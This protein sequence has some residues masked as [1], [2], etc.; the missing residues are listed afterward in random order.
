MTILITGG[1]GYIGSH[2]CVTFLEA[3]HDVVVVDNLTNANPE[4]LNRV[5][6]ITGRK[7][8]F[9][10]ADIRDQPAMERLLKA[11]ACDAVVHFAGLKAVGESTEKPLEY[12]DNNV[13]GTIKLLSAMVASGVR[14]LIFS[15]SA[16]VY[17]EPEQLPIPEDHPLK[18]SNPYGRSKLMIEDILRDLALSDPSWRIGILRYFNPVGAHPSGLIGEDPLSEPSNLMPILAQVASGRRENL[19]VFGAD[20]DTCDGTGVRDYIHVVDLVEGHLKAYEALAAL[21]PADNCMTVNLGTG[22]GYSVLEMV[23]A[24]ERASNK[25]INYEIAPRR[26]ADIGVSFASTGQAKSQL[27]W[28]ARFDLEA[29][30]R[31]TWNWTCKN[32]QGY[33]GDS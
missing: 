7:L 16:N 17:G 22:T 20:Y 29:M 30:C 11:H 12:Y 1:A 9:E 3:G 8:T 32:P 24:F 6:A 23:K 19:Q 5:A 28:T 21:E 15:S 13:G 31:D 26:P 18:T 27:G 33:G 10:E 2:C 25:P 4:S 14:K